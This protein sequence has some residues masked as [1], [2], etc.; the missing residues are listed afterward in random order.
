[1]S[2]AGAHVRFFGVVNRA[3]SHKRALCCSTLRIVSHP[4]V[5]GKLHL[6]M[7]MLYLLFSVALCPILLDSE[8]YFMLQFL[9]GQCC[10]PQSTVSPC[11]DRPHSSSQGSGQG[12]YYHHAYVCSHVSS[13]RRH[14]YQASCHN[15]SSV[16]CDVTDWLGRPP[17]RIRYLHAA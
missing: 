12:C 16:S 4:M 3:H 15:D 7:T 11:H 5:A 13:L 8:L 9:S 10:I 2:V 14:A 6:L 1:M 17:P